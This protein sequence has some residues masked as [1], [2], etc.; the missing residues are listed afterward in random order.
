MHQPKQ[1]TDDVIRIVIPYKDQ[2]AAVSVKRQLRDLSSKVRK[3]IQPVFTSRKSYIS[4][5]A[6]I[7]DFHIFINI[8]AGIYSSVLSYIPFERGKN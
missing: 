7:D 4:N 1:H 3:I 2:D 8:S 6:K 5:L